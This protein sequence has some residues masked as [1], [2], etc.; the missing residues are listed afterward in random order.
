MIRRLR[1]AAQVIAWQDA[2]AL[3]VLF[4]VCLHL[5]VHGAVIAQGDAAPIITASNV[6]VKTVPAWNNFGDYFGRFG[7]LTPYAPYLAVLSALQ[8]VV[9]A[10]LAQMLLTFITLA[11]GYLGFV[12]LLRRLGIMNA[13]VRF[14]CGLFYWFSPFTQQ[15][16]ITFTTATIFQAALPWSLL[17]VRS[18]VQHNRVQRWLFFTVFAFA[19]IPLALVAITPQLLVEFLC[20]NVVFGCVFF[21]IQGQRGNAATILRYCGGGC[22]GAAWWIIPLALAYIGVQSSRSFA[23]TDNSWI[24]AHASFLNVLRFAS[25]W[26]WYEPIYFPYER[27]FDSNVLVYASTMIPVAGLAASLTVPSR[28]NSVLQ[29]FIAI[30]AVFSFS[31]IKGVHEPLGMLD[32]AILSLPIAFLFQESAGFIILA[33]LCCL[34]GTAYFLMSLRKWAGF[35]SAVVAVC[36]ILSGWPLIS[37]IVY[38]KGFSGVTSQYVSVPDAYAEAARFVKRSGIFVLPFDDGYQAEYRWGFLGSDVFPESIFSGRTLVPSPAIGYV[39]N[40]R[41]ASFAQ[42]I[43]RMLNSRPAAVAAVL[44]S[45]GIRYV[46][47]RADVIPRSF[48]TATSADSLY[49]AFSGYPAR[50]I[51]PLTIFDL[52][53]ETPD[54]FL[55]DRIVRVDDASSSADKMIEEFANDGMPRVA[56]DGTAAL[57]IS[58]EATS[59]IKSVAE[60]DVPSIQLTNRGVHSVQLRSVPAHLSA[61]TLQ[62]IRFVPVPGDPVAVN[63]EHIDTFNPLNKPARADVHVRVH[64]E[65]SKCFGLFVDDIGVSQG[66]VSQ[67]DVPYADAVFSGIAFAPGFHDVVVRPLLDFTG[68]VERPAHGFNASKANFTR[69]P[70]YIDYRGSGIVRAL[71]NTSVVPFGPSALIVAAWKTNYSMREPHAIAIADTPPGTIFPSAG[72]YYLALR[73]TVRGEAPTFC[74]TPLNLGDILELAPLVTRCLRS[75]LGARNMANVLVSQIL[76]LSG[77]RLPGVTVNGPRGIVGLVDLVPQNGDSSAGVSGCKVLS[78]GGICRRWLRFVEHGS[79]I[80]TSNL[81]LPGANMRPSLPRFALSFAPASKTRALDIGFYTRASIAN[82]KLYY[83]NGREARP[84]AYLL[85]GFTHVAITVPAG[86]RSWLRGVIDT[87]AKSVDVIVAG[88][89]SH[90]GVPGSSL[91]LRI[92]NRQDV[93]SQDVAAHAAWYA[94]GKNRLAVNAAFVVQQSFNRYWI[95][96]TL[97]RPF[98]APHFAANNWE[99]AW[100]V[101]PGQSFVAINLIVPLEICCFIVGPIVCLWIMLRLRVRYP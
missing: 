11:A 97:N 71:Q 33:L 24:Y 2:A 74:T 75:R 3:A 80:G 85:D 44:R 41:Q 7:P 49:Q 28:R 4:T 6:F 22:V 67:Q 91:L 68:R 56:E 26:F 46:V 29:K 21:L 38:H 50:R 58:D 93:R 69:D 53:K 63:N 19:F 30:V 55:V 31:I 78:V 14:A 34:V 59:R 15:T 17:I 101:R 70:F 64:D 98:I 92:G 27:S 88:T 99:N 51:G 81:R 84:Q 60:R 5:S 83:E 9:G 37:G 94:F 90:G 72:A 39:A 95:C 43:L 62:R 40:S 48:I 66:C 16:L 65:L 54:A 45:V 10:S 79:G 61:T 1:A 12:L 25:A 47:Y 8:A 82:L 32:R 18:L 35:A 86:Q 23:V 42:Y 57:G 73:L 100:L 87:A 77:T 20:I 76:V 89:V 52:G 96:V 13:N 36:G